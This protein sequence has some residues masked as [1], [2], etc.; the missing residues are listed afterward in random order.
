MEDGI[1]TAA[2]TATAAAAATAT[3]IIKLVPSYN[4]E[5]NTVSPFFMNYL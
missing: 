3:T 1:A 2:V 4:I 5:W